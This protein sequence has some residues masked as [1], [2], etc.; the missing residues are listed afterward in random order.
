MHGET[1]KNGF[2]FGVNWKMAVV[3]GALLACA[4]MPVG[5]IMQRASA[6]LLERIRGGTPPE[7]QPVVEAMK[8]S[9]AVWDRLA[10]AFMALIL[11]PI[12]EEILFRGILYPT[13]KRYNYPRLALWGTSL[14]FAAIH[15]NLLTFVPLFLFAIALTL[16]YRHTGNLVA[17]ITAH[18]VF[19][20]LNFIKF[21]IFE[22]LGPKP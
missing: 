1:V 12:S 19:N 9:S 17:P 2:G 3:Y 18:A 5:E 21:L 6:V 14:L 10:L 4:F 8:H 16:L 13:V 11:A 15:V 20:L 7:V 22:S